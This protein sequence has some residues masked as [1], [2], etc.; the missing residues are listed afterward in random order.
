MSKER[1]VNQ[2][3]MVIEWDP[4]DSIYIVTVPELPG[5]RTHGSTREEAVHKGEEVIGLWL[6][7]EELVP[8]PATFAYWPSFND[9]TGMRLIL[10]GDDEDD[11]KHYQEEEFQHAL[12]LV[13]E[14]KRREA[15]ATS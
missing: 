14:A 2:Y 3:S 6:Y 5:C 8:P 13:E 11:A 4:R 15:E 9:S 10:S 1:E 7:G 12:A